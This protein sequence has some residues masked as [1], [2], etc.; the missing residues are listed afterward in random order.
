LNGILAKRKLRQEFHALKTVSGVGDVL[1]PTIALE[2]GD[3]HRF[4]DAP[5]VGK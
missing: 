2:T 4:R 5:R 1:A 3:V